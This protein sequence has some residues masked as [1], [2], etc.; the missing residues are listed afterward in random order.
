MKSI[1]EDFTTTSI[2]DWNFTSWKS[3]IQGLCK[4]LTY[5]HL[6]LK[7]VQASAKEG[8]E[9]WS[10]IGFKGVNIWSRNSA[11][12]SPQTSLTWWTL[13]INIIICQIGRR[14]ECIWLNF[15]EAWSLTLII[16]IIVTAQNL[17][18]G[19]WDMNQIGPREKKIWF[20]KG[21]YT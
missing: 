12:I 18:Y 1:F 13:W 15:N 19:T 20:K 7:P 17:T 21:F 6:L 4:Y 5:K 10:K 9:L 14:G 2:S 3:V 8:G 11:Q 16:S